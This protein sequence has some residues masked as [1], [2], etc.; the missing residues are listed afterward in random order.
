MEVWTGE[1]RPG[2]D[3]VKEYHFHLY[4]MQNNKEQ[5]AKINAFPRTNVGNVS[6]S[7]SSS[8][9]VAADIVSAVKSGRF[10]VVCPGVTS[11][12]LPGLRGTNR[13]N[14]GPRGPHPVAS[15]ETWVPRESLAEFLSF[16]M[17]RRRGLS[18][19]VHPL[20][21]ISYKVRDIAKSN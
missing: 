17:H 15:F 12:V 16:I 9:V 8:E 7:V 18:V 11:D 5:G 20:G 10:V 4:W 21:R 1:I 3:S 13:V 14:P 2:H 6:V 19:L